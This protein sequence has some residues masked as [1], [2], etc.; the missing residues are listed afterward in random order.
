MMIALILKLSPFIPT[1]ASFI[2][3]LFAICFIS[4][5]S[6]LIALY[7]EKPL[8]KLIKLF[9]SLIIKKYVGHR[10]LKENN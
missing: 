2:L 1:N 9:S 8:K 5:L 4:L 10:S 6:Y 7:F 3:P